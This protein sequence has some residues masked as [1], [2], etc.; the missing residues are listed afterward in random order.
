MATKK[1][2]FS[3]LRRVPRAGALAFS[4]LLL[5]TAAHAL[6]MIPVAASETVVPAEPEA[7]ASVQAAPAEVR[8]ASSG[9]ILA[10]GVFSGRDPFMPVPLAPKTEERQ[11]QARA[12]PKGYKPDPARLA[13]R[14]L[15]QIL[16]TTQVQ[17]FDPVS[18]RSYFA[19]AGQLYDSKL[20]PVDG[21][22]AAVGETEVT[23]VKG[24]KTTVVKF[25]AKRK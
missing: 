19:A 4:V 18:G 11:P 13:F 17:L 21:I 1:T 6:E 20:K 8:R 2:V 3:A 22:T 14:G 7:G 10:G 15:S 12:L 23:L 25:A 24:G 9:V 5:G 16:K